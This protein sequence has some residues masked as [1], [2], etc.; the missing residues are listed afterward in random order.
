MH[1]SEESDIF[2][3]SQSTTIP[4]LCLVRPKFHNHESLTPHSLPQPLTLM[5]TLVHELSTPGSP[6]EWNPTVLADGLFWRS[7]VS[8]WISSYLHLKNLHL[9]REC[10]KKWVYKGLG[11]WG[12]DELGPDQL[13]HGPS[14]PI[15]WLASSACS[16]F[17]GRQPGN[18]Y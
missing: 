15:S 17:L 11:V 1:V 13:P 4:S 6:L 9:G 10:M 8:V 2:S 5:S 7:W 3:F 16:N 18:I 14:C 12:T